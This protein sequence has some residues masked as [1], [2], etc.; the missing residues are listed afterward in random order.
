[1]TRHWWVWIVYGVIFIIVGA[2]HIVW[3]ATTHDPAIGARFGSTLISLGIIV[4]AQP[5]FRTGLPEAVNRQM[6][7]GLLEAVNRP[8]PAGLPEAVN[9]P[10]PASVPEAVKHQLP[11]QH[12]SGY[13]LI[14]LR[15][16]QKEEHKAVRPGIVHDVVAERVIGVGIILV[17]TLVHGYGDLPLR[18]MGYG[19]L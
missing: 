17:G 8:V 9:R 2:G 14:Q 5:F 4:T 6:P 19:A 13:S 11:G 18:W 7:A 1:M 12:P 3:F 10:M 16:Q 15:K